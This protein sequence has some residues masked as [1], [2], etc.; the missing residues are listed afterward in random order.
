[1]RGTTNFQLQQ[2]ILELEGKAVES[3]FW[4][5]VLKDLQKPSRQRRQVN[6]YKIEKYA[7]QGETVLVPG[8][9]LSV[10]NLNKKVDVAAFNFSEEAKKKIENAKGKVLTIQELI[11]QNP[12]GKKV[13]ILG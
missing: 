4:K 9:V 10:G 2:V 1:M 13:R 5:R 7:K 11:Q 6:V 12:E 3:K 8:K